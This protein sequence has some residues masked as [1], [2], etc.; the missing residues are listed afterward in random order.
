MKKYHG[1]TMVYHNKQWYTMVDITCTMVHFIHTMVHPCTTI[2]QLPYTMGCYDVPWYNLVQLWYIHGTNN[3]VHGM[4]SLTKIYYTPFPNLPEIW[5]AEKVS[6][7]LVF[8][9]GTE[10]VHHH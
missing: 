9:S 4:L 1:T 5:L 10:P 3:I 2:V 6:G 7:R 8:M